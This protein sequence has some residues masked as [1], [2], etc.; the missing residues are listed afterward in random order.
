M[1]CSSLTVLSTP[2]SES[3]QYG[4]RLVIHDCASAGSLGSSEVSETL[5]GLSDDVGGE[6]ADSFLDRGTLASFVDHDHAVR[7]VVG[8]IVPARMDLLLIPGDATGGNEAILR[9]DFRQVAVIG[10]E[11]LGTVL[12][13]IDQRQLTT[14]APAIVEQ[15]LQVTLV[16]ER[17][18]GHAVR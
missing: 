1:N 5:A 11:R 3:F 12:D 2:S 8:R 10:I 17:I 18:A 7:V 9:I 4:L 16:V 14:A 13:R 6:G 15:I